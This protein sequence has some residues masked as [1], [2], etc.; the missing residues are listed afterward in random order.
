MTGRR[1]L[2][3]RLAADKS[4]P[5]YLSVHEL[6]ACWE[7]EEPN[8]NKVLPSKE[9]YFLRRCA[10]A[11]L[12]LLD[13][14]WDPVLLLSASSVCLRGVVLETRFLCCSLYGSSCLSLLV[15]LAVL[16]FALALAFGVVFSEHED[17]EELLR[18]RLWVPRAVFAS[19]AYAKIG[20]W[21]L[22]PIP[23]FSCSICT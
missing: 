19:F 11:F 23:A 14:G 4:I 17:A 1:N 5:A 15:I 10:P 21:W 22:I 9:L 12:D 20:S 3:P 7:T 8:S 2:G 16:A 6:A 13:S 18:L